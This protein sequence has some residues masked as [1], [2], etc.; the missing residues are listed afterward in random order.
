M[1]FSLAQL[2]QDSP[3]QSYLYSYPHKTAYRTLEQP[4]DLQNTWAQEDKSALFLYIHI[5]FCAMRCGFCNLFTL[6]QP[7]GDLAERYV[8][9]LINQM[10]ITSEFL[11]D[12]QFEGFACGGGTP[13]FLEAKQLHQIFATAHDVL[14]LDLHTISG[15]IETSPETATIERL[16]VCKD[17]GFERISMGL[18]SFYAAEV[19]ALAR[20]QKW[21]DV[22]AAIHRIHQ[23]DF[24]ILNLDLIYGIPGQTVQTFLDTLEA[25]LRYTPEELYLYPLYIRPLTGLKKIENNAQRHTDEKSIQLVQQHQQAQDLRLEMYTTA[26]DYLL[27]RGYEQISMRMF[28]RKKLNTLHTPDDKGHSIDEF[29]KSSTRQRAADSTN[30]TAKRAN[31]VIGLKEFGYSCQE[32]GMVGLGCGARSYTRNLHYSEEYGIARSRISD[33]LADYC[34]RNPQDFKT[35][36]YGI[37]ISPQEQQRRFAIQSLLLCTGLSLADYTKRFGSNPMTDLPQLQ[38]LLDLNLATL[39]SKKLVLNARGISY[40]D[41]IGPWLISPKVHERMQAYE[42]A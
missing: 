26:R 1:Q 25:A 36:R 42:L 2:I 31:N 16:Q 27:A 17:F 3:Y 21:Q 29:F 23:M 24:P 20:K 19:Q 30:S 40:A 22:D 18:Q 34:N 38:E 32:D 6:A 4:V 5:P 10:H 15:G 8:Q 39:D 13:T 7:R 14:G 11:G 37:H 35:A 33:I 41:A 28:K 12:H 9:Q